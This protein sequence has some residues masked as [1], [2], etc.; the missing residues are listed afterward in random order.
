MHL[1]RQFYLILGKIGSSTYKK[2]M[3]S[4]KNIWALVTLPELHRPT[5]VDILLYNVL[6]HV[7]I[8]YS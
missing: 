3:N 7:F 6:G 5:R 8:E 4:S 2:Q 1:D